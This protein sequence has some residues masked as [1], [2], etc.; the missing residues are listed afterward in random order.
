MLY[1]V[2]NS[3]SNY[4]RNLK[5]SKDQFTSY[6]IGTMSGFDMPAST[7]SLISEWDINY[8]LGIS[9][10]DKVTLKKQVLSTKLADVVK[11]HELFD[12]LYENASKYTIGNE[13]KV[14]EHTFDD[15]KVL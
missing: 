9:K 3:I 7:P 13:V 11:C 1:K 15:V 14:K 4:L 8:L 5:V 12:L 10:K 2:F 6:V